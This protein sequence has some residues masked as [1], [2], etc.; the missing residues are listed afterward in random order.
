MLSQFQGDKVAWPVYLTIGNISKEVRRQ[1]SMHATVLLAYLPV[2]K[3]K[4]FEERTRSLKKYC[5][6][7]HCMT[8]LLQPLVE[9]GR[10]GVEMICA[11]GWRRHVHP[12]LAAYVADFPEQCLVACC[13]ENRCPNVW[14]PMIDVE[15]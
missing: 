9:A 8:S 14:L 5:F 12:I 15:S 6:F 7:H 13:K 2:P 1:P 3:F 11:D 10:A 4:C